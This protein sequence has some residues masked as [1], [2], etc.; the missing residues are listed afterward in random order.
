M[1]MQQKVV[2]VTGGSSGVGQATAVVF[3]RQG[4][5]VIV[6]GR[7][8]KGLDETV[9]HVRQAGG[10]AQKITADISEP[11]DIQRMIEQALAVYGQLDI[12]VNNAGTQGEVAPLVDQRLASF[13]EVFDTNVRSVFLCMKYAIPHLLNQRGAIVNIA[14]GG[15][16]VGV[17]GASVYCASKHAV[18]GMTKVA[19]LDYATAGLRVNAVCPGGV[20]TPM[21]QRFFESIPD[22]DA[23]RQARE[24][25][26]ATHPIG[27]IA[28]PEEVAAAV[29]FLCS[30]DAAFITGTTLS[31][32]GGYVAH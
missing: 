13:Q 32:D 15:G 28:K 12:L 22:P 31:V 11:N 14:S 19:A 6:T 17:P 16:L 24:E 4:I 23:R 8:S 7:N 29:V 1:E 18:I 9:E 5:R 25:F 2:L 21:L 27:R 3:G 30:P 20:D 26:N 10:V